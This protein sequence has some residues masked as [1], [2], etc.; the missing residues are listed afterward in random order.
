MSGDMASPASSGGEGSAE[1]VT[2][3]KNPA[4]VAQ[5]IPLE[6]PAGQSSSAVKALRSLIAL[7]AI[8]AI[9]WGAYN[10][11]WP[12]LRA[13]NESAPE[14]A[15]PAPLEPAPAPQEVPVAPLAPTA[16]MIGTPGADIATVTA[17]LT[18]SGIIA[19]LS[20]EARKGA[21]QGSSIRE[22]SVNGPTG[23]VSFPGLIA[24]LLP[25]GQPS[26]LADLFA[27]G[28]E[29]AFTSYIFHDDKGAWPGYI[30]KIA[31]GGPDIV[32]LADR[33][34][35]LESA[36]YQNFFLSSPGAAQAFR[37]GQVKEQYMNRFA[38]FSTPGA[39]F[40]YGIF[41]QYVIINTS[42][43]GLLRALELLAL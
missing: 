35:K 24:A 34:Q 23:A 41:G 14:Q 9:G 31:Q 42:Y 17:D 8:V 10:Y 39:S 1:L 37:T 2:F 25:E 40:N 21:P 43:G 3:P 26:G 16:S 33:L 20:A 38:A 28:F 5:P 19:G 15:I 30:V 27:T 18:P 7:I 12:A 11:G 36:S 22:V 13:M 4:P 32:T 29:S 6:L